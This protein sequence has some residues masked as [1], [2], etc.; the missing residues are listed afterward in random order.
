[1]VK[2][3]IAGGSGNVAQ[4]IIDV[5]VATKKH[6]ILLLSR[7]DAPTEGTAP[8]VRWIRTKYEDTQELAAVLQGVHT[9]LSFIVVHSDIG[10]VSQRNLIDAAIQAGVKRFAPSE[11]ASSSFEHMDWYAGKA[12]IRKY[13]EHL[14][15]HEKVL[16]YSLFQPGIFTNYFTHPHKSASHVVPIETPIDFQRHRALVVDG[17]DNA[18][19][20]LTTV[21]DLAQ[22]V[23][24]AVEYTGE[25]PVIGGIRG[26]ELTVKQLIAIG[27]KIRGLFLAYTPVFSRSREQALTR[28]VAGEHFAV[29][30]LK[31]ED[32][33]AGELKSSWKPTA[34]HPAFSEEQFHAISAKLMS[35]VLLGI[36]AGALHVSDEWNRLLPEYRFSQAEDFLAEAWR[37]KA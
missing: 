5:L 27:E 21:Q 26:T 30:R 15:K 4:E 23:A 28:N 25:W 16:E 29:E 33:E 20:T 35:G 36:S 1:M 6:D 14:N 18:R 17:A 2:I 3:A 37:D 10:N 12:E 11:W 13:L 7:Q 22:V 31:A 8:G 34:R 19:L 32:L 24:L 9:V